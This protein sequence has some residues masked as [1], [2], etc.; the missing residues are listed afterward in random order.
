M[1]LTGALQVVADLHQEHG[2]MLTADG[3]FT[4]LGG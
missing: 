3:M 2:V 1:G 4:L